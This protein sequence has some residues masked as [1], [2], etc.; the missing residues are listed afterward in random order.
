[1]NAYESIASTVSAAALIVAG[2]VSEL[3]A[4]VENDLKDETRKT[5]VHYHE[6]KPQPTSRR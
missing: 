2:F 3:R 6:W 5:I 1:M 4:A